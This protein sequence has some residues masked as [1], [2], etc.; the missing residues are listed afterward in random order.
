MGGIE[1]RIL[2]EQIHTPQA[3]HQAVVV[4]H[5][6]GGTRHPSVLCIHAQDVGCTHV[7]RK[8]GAGGVA[9][10]DAER[11]KAGDK[12]DAE[13]GHLAK[14]FGYLGTANRIGILGSSDGILFCLLTFLAGHAFGILGRDDA[15]LLVSILDEGYAVV[16]RLHG[17]RK[18]SLYLGGR[19][20]SAA[21][22]GQCLS[23]SHEVVNGTV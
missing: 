1:Q 6:K 9:V 14:E 17:A 11:F 8:N 20:Q 13:V 19:V 18:G 21:L 15:L 12:A 23:G 10:L 16:E 5:N 22:R 4:S 2:T 3:F 7:T